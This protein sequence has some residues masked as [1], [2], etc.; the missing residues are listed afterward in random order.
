MFAFR[1]PAVG[2]VSN[3][4]EESVRTKKNDLRATGS[5]LD[6]SRA[7]SEHRKF[8]LFFLALQKHNYGCFL[9]FIVLDFE[10]KLL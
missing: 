1:Y 3:F 9:L 8:C 7:C 5:L 4:L 2:A 10:L 6:I